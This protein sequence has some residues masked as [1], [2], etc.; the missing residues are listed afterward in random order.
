MLNNKPALMRAYKQTTQ[1]D[2]DGD[3]W[4]EKFE[5]PALLRN[6]VFFNKIYAVFDDV[7]TGDDRRIDFGEFKAGLGKVGLQ[8]DDAKAK[9]EFAKIDTNG[10]G[11]VLF[12]EFCIWVAET[13]CPVSKDFANDGKKKPAGAANGKVCFCREIK[14]G[15]IEN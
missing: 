11:Q 3:P 14:S 4:V 12:D 1:R 10:G 6:L 15:K 7:D 5:F 9:Q 2:G 13:T 8:Y